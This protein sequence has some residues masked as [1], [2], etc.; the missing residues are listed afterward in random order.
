MFTNMNTP[1]HDDDPGGLGSLS[2]AFVDRCDDLIADRCAKRR[3]PHLT[4]TSRD[5]E[6]CGITDDHVRSKER[7]QTK[8]TATQGPNR[9]LCFK[10]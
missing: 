10:A 2:T 1:D 5:T 9:T 3:E 7:D 4:N 8:L 6:S